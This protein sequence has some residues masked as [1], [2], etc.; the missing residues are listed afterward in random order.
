M[1]KCNDRS[2]RTVLLW[3]ILI[4]MITEV[5][6]RIRRNKMC[7]S[8]HDVFWSRQR[9]Q[10]LNSCQEWD[11]N[12]RLQ[13]ETRIPKQFKA[14]NPFDTGLSLAP[15]TTR[16][17]WQ[18]DLL[19]ITRFHPVSELFGHIPLSRDQILE[20]LWQ[21]VYEGLRTVGSEKSNICIS[22]SRMY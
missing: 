18:L 10:K 3:S 15:L 8:G 7:F 11:S 5:I 14:L 20:V 4:G 12:P 22:L 19:T 13:Q 1:R 21:M 9:R 17:S 16:P 2:Q 6:G